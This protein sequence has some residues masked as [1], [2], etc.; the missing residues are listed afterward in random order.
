MK[1]IRFGVCGLGRIGLVHCKHFSDQRQI[2]ELAAGCDREPQRVSKLVEDYR[3][4]GY[5]CFEEFLTK[6]DM[7][8]VIIATRSLDHAANALQALEAGKYVLLEK[9]IAVTHDDFQ[10]LQNADRKYPGKLFFLHNHRFEPAFQN[11]IKLTASSILGDIHEV[12][13][14]KHHG[15]RRRADWQAL[16]ACGGGQ[17]SCWGPHIIDHALQFINAPVKDV[18]SHLKRITSPGDADDHVKI[19]I[20]GENDIVVDLEI[21]DAPAWR[22]NSCTVYGSRGSLICADE[23]NIQLNYIDPEFDFPPVTASADLPPV[24]GGYGSEE[25]LPWI[26]KTVKVEPDTNVWEQVEIDIAKHLYNAI[27]L[28][29]PFPITNAQALEVVRITELVKKQNRHFNYL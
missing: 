1:A 23:K 18:W 8:L 19:L 20:V 24:I 13:L 5:S 26:Q 16:L 3:C 9:P 11:I 27:R 10:I 25:K 6:S 15:F 4:E 21:S 22:S 2:Y 29:I 28:N 12:K 14:R 17:L 7:Q